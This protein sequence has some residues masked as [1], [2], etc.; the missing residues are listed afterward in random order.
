MQ[1]NLHAFVLLALPLAAIAL[2]ARFGVVPVLGV[3][4]KPVISRLALYCVGAVAIFSLYFPCLCGSGNNPNLQRY[5]PLA[6]GLLVSLTVSRPAVRRAFVAL[7]FVAQL[8]LTFHFQSLVLNPDACSF[9]GDPSYI[10][11]SC[12]VK[13]TAAPLWHTRVTGIH[14]IHKL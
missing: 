8:G 2:A 14:E 3:E 1:G 5:L 10:E 12:S 4:L 9:T 6:A 11:N 13:A 7:S